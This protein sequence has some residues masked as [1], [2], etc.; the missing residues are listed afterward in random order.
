[1]PLLRQCGFSFLIAALLGAC[2]ARPAPKVQT[3]F[4]GENEAVKSVPEAIEQ[5][6]ELR[7]HGADRVQILLRTGT[8]ALDTPLVL[9][10]KDSGLLIAAAPR[11]KPVIS[12]QAVIRGWKTSAVNPNVW[13]T[14]IDD[15]RNGNWVFHELFV[16]GQ[17]KSRI[18]LPEQGFYHADGKGIPGQPTELKFHP[19]DIK[20]E[21]ANDGNVELVLYSAWAQSRN[22]I[23]HV[24]E[25]SNVVSL[26]GQAFPNQNEPNARY[27]IENAPV[28]LRPGQWHLD[29]RTGVLTYW[30]EA[31]E[32]IPSATVTAPHLYDLVQLKG[33]DY[34]AVRGVTFRGIIFQNADWRLDGGSDVDMQAAVEIPGA[35]K[36]EFAHDCAFEGC[37]FE[38][39]GGYAVELGRGC[40]H[41]RIAGNEMRDLGA[42][43]IRVGGGDADDAFFYSCERHQITD[44]HIH[45][46]GLVSAP[47]VGIFIL[48]SSQNEIAHNEIDHTF[49]TGISLGWSWGYRKTYCEKNI[50]EFNHIHDIGQGMLSDMGG[51]YT[52]G[53]QPGAIIRDNLIHDVNILTYGGWGLYTDEGSSGITLESNIV[54]HCQSAGFHQHYGQNNILRNNIFAL[55]KDAELARTRIQKG[56]SFIFTNNIAYC[57]T[58]ALFTGNWGS[59]EQ[60]DNNLYF[61]TRTNAAGLKNRDALSRWQKRGHD[62]HSLFADPRFAN[63]SHFNFHLKS[64]SP[65]L[66]LGFQQMDLSTVGIRPKYRRP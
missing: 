31:G 10:A 23:R 56:V 36:A 60:M 29:V 2:S 45:D 1:M 4:V 17:R 25:D 26:A 16:N 54:Y 65:A 33:D 57:D 32:D 52:L 53:L 30:P 62:K 47:A 22:Q 64:N 46:I 15:V 9:T 39:L 35:L 3:L 38:H 58:G 8:Y 12:G 43:G 21:W 24:F 40:K 6:R 50:V 48:L 28:D 13:Q 5:A 42:G 63:P 66:Q 49:Y 41:C 27:I 51:I 34:H 37:T 59:D 61:D 20:K 19:G 18:R 55:N 14:E 44:N 11:A 7:H